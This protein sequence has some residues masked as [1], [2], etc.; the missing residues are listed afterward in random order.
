MLLKFVAAYLRDYCEVGGVRPEERCGFR[1][2]RSTVNMLF[3]VR[4]LQQSG[5]ARNTPLYMYFIDLRNAYD[6]GDRNV[7]LVVLARFGVPK[8]ISLTSIHQLYKGIRAG[9][10]TDDGEHPD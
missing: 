8:K 6:S 7:F 2:T 3:V 5:R 4:H 9:V 1:P 10:R